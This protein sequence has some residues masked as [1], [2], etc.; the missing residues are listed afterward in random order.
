ME[1]NELVDDNSKLSLENENLMTKLKSLERQLDESRRSVGDKEE[2]LKTSEQLLL[3]LDQQLMSK[4]TELEVMQLTY[5]KLRDEN[6]KISSEKLSLEDKIHN[7]EITMAECGIIIGPAANLRR[8]MSRSASA[9]QQVVYRAREVQTELSWQEEMQ[10][11]NDYKD[12]RERHDVLQ[13]KYDDEVVD[14]E[15][16][17]TEIT[18][19]LMLKNNLVSTLTNQIQLLQDEIAALHEGFERERFMHNQKMHE[20]NLVAQRVPFLGKRVVNNFHFLVDIV[21]SRC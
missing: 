20:V 21:D 5:Q 6:D 10:I 17:V 12:L 2:S 8:K 1:Y 14:L 13:Q 15:N 16:R 7:L 18:A 9:H 4:R 11:E 3:S 19:N